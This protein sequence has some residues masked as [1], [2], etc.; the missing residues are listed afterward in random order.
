MEKYEKP[1]MEVVDFG[2]DV[3]ETF[4][5]SFPGFPQLPG[6]H[7]ATGNQGASC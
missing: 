6:I 4:G 2:D 1:V 3:I 5:P 7:G